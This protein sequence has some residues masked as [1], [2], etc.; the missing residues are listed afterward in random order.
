MKMFR[1]LSDGI[2]ALIITIMLYAVF[3]TIVFMTP[4]DEMNNDLIA[5]ATFISMTFF[6]NFPLCW[7]ILKRIIRANRSKNN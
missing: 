7:W 2:A 5:L 3:F 4:G 1:K 6:I